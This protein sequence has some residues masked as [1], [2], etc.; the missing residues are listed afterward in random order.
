MLTSY[1][2]EYEIE[3]S[4]SFISSNQYYYSFSE[5]LLSFFLLLRFS[6]QTLQLKIFTVQLIFI[7]GEI[8]ARG[9]WNIPDDTSKEIL[10][11]WFKK[12]IENTGLFD[13]KDA[14]YFSQDAGS[15]NFLLFG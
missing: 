12:K 10:P 9:Y 3:N 1:H 7:Q 4:V 14:L 15:D 8:C 5:C 11:S 6:S 13:L 2:V